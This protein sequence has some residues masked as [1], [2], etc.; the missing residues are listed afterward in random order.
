MTCSSK[1]Q[2]ALIASIT[3]GDRIKNP[4]NKE[5]W[6]LCLK[7]R[8]LV[9][10]ICAPKIHHDPIAYMKC[11]IE[12]YVR[13]RA[14]LFP[15]APL[16]PKHHYLLHYPEL[17]LKFGSLIYKRHQLMQAYLSAGSIFSPNVQVSESDEFHVFKQ[18]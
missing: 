6:Q 4:L 7:L 8:N 9:E 16:K 11:M 3:N 17:T 14:A 10:M 2:S 15:G 12:E 5:I 1:H 13:L 18:L